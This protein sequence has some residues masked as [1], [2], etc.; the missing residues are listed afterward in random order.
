MPVGKPFLS[1]G[2]R[3]RS[4]SPVRIGCFPVGW[5]FRLILL[6]L[7]GL[8]SP[9]H[10]MATGTWLPLNNP[11]PNNI[12]T[13]LLLPDGTVIATDGSPMS[14]EIGNSWYR[15][16]PDST[17]SYLNGTWSTLAPMTYLRLYY[18]SQVLTNGQVFIAGA[19]YGTGTNA[20]EVYDPL[21]DTWTVAPP[22]PAGQS[23]YLDSISEIIANGNVLVAPVGPAAYGGTDI[24]NVISNL[25]VAGP[26]LVNSGDE[27]EASW[28]KLPDASIITIDPFGTDSERYIPSLNQWVNDSTVPVAMYDQANGE[29]GPAFLLKDGRAFYIG[30]TG[31]TAFYTPSGTTNAGVWQAGPQLPNSQVAA[32]A[33]GAMMVNGKV[34]YTMSSAVYSSDTS[35]YEYDSTANSF[36]AVAAP[37]PDVASNYTYVERMLDLPDGTVLFSSSTP[38]LY[39]YLPDGVPLAAGQPVINTLTTNSDGSYHLT[40]RLFNGISEGAA[41]GDD[42]Q[43]GSNYPLVRMTN[44]LGQVYYGRTYHWSSTG[45]MTGTNIV[46]TDFAVPA[47]FSNG[48]YS[49]V[50]VANGNASAPV[51]F[52]YSHDAFLVR[53]TNATPAFSRMI[54]QPFA[55]ANI[56]FA[57]TNLSASSLNWS[58]NNTSAWLNVSSNGGTLGGHA[59]TTVTVGLNAAAIALGPGTYTATMWFTNL[60]NHFL[61]QEV[62]KLQV[63]PLVQNGDFETG[64]FTG[65]NLNGDS[66]PDNFPDYGTASNIQPHSGNYAALMGEPE[67]LAYLSQTIPT[68]NGQ[69][70]LYS[71]WLNSPDGV[72]PNECSIS[73]NGTTL[74]DQ[75]NM[76]A[77]GWTNLLF[78]VTA[79]GSNAVIQIGV[80]DDN[81]FLGLDDIS[82][83]PI[84]PPVLQS[85]RVSRGPVNLS[86]SALNGLAYQLQYRTNLTQGSWM[87]LGSTITATNNTA[88]AAD[89]APTDKQRFY[90]VF[91]IP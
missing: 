55:P 73:W 78:K 77:I 84:Y 18:S 60:S 68:T 81:S 13:M 70:Y 69:L 62:I 37:S 11:A 49:L 50:V 16:T 48:V 46:S 2:N 74:F 30:A 54:G 57:L 45:V 15:L 7:S 90:R 12:D 52:N 80:Q 88:T 71:V 14:G 91:L 4:I 72:T 63:N 65:W 83:T 21:A 76:P 1:G 38:Q 43:M 31:N 41:Y 27:D 53:N 67:F 35:F 82:V 33:P 5:I 22:P 61:Q 42:A 39:V 17:G 59:A 44:S 28:V 10:S 26:I 79:T 8:L 66:F 34:L 56:S 89:A 87:N 23:Y 24:Y 20:A 85:T 86:W 51:A 64:D 25:V 3:S 47:N 75:V 40:G 9:S 29:M 58:L 36:T 19:E 6:L 32:D